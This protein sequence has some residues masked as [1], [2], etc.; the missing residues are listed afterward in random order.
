MSLDT[1]GYGRL[2]LVAVGANTD[3]LVDVAGYYQ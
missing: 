2:R 1:Y 3:V